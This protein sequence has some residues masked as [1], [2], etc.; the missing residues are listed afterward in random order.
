MKI[1][2]TNKN[3]RQHD[4]RSDKCP[5][6]TIQVETATHVLHCPEA[7][8][9]EAFQ[10]GTTALEQW[11]QKADTDLDLT[12]SIVEYVQRRGT[13]TM[14]KAIVDA[15]LMFRQMALS[16]DKMETV[17]RGDDIKGDHIHSAAVHCC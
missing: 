7:G 12:D 2:A 8:R 9:V 14:E 3:M 11:L 1:A 16:Q 6:C 17:P 10:L 15:P 5:C 4:R 13:I